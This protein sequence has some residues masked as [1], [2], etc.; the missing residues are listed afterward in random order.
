MTAQF[1]SVH[2]YRQ[3]HMQFLYVEVLQALFRFEE[4]GPLSDSHFCQVQS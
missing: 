1:D 4:A 3:P 2:S